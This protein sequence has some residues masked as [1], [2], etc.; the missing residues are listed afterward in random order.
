MFGCKAL[1]QSS[2]LTNPQVVSSSKCWV[3]V[4]DEL[5]TISRDTPWLREECGLILCDSVEI[6]RSDTHQE[7]AV[8]LIERLIDC[9]FAK[10]A[11]GVAVWL[12]I[13]S[14]FSESIL[15]DNVWHDK[16]PLT[17]KERKAL[18][19]ALAESYTPSEEATDQKQIKTGFSQN[20]LNFAWDRV[21]AEIVRRQPQA[22]A[23]DSK[24][25]GSLDF[26]KFW[27]DVVDG[28]V[29]AQL[30]GFMF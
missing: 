13:G 28:K 8:K 25:G 18:A 11:E 20:S 16:D 10:T 12:A 29:I 27:R 6:L 2:I 21:I 22:T 5:L 14:K 3:K 15:P 30:F 7:Y 9:G 17:T 26:A 19:N 1:V 24:S 23:F 4:I